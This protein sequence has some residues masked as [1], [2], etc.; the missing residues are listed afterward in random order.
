MSNINKI[1]F[2]VID[3]KF[4]NEINIEKNIYVS[5]FLKNLE[6]DIIINIAE[7]SK[8]DFYGF[9]SEISPKNI[10]INQFKNN[11]SLN[12][13]SLFISN[14]SNLISNIAS[15]INS[16]NSK[17]YLNII[18]I[19]KENKIWIDSSIKI[20]KNS[21][22]I[23]AKLELE[24]IFIWEKWTIN[25]IPKLFIYS[26]DVQ[27]SHSSKTQRIPDDKLFYLE[28]RWLDKKNSNQILLESYFIQ[29]FSCLEMYNKDIFKSIN[30]EFL[31]LNLN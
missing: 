18:S 6:N 15:Q 5:L 26:N 1:W 23:E 19:I 12:F 24:N 29:I 3:K 11:S 21:K 2:Y 27:V 30:S 20:E 10:I 4:W 31:N 7:N 9:F 25:S 17:A 14:N 16:L 8:V 13:K 22:K 28:S